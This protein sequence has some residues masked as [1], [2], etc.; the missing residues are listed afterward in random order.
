MTLGTEWRLGLFVD[1]LA[2]EKGLSDRTVDAYLRDV[3]R[4]VSWLEGSDVRPSR[5]DQVTP[6][7]LREHIYDLKDRSYAAST[8]RRA[9]AS[10]RAYFGFLVEEEGLATDPTRLLDTPRASRTLPEVLSVEAVTALLEDFPTDRFAYWRDRSILELLYATGMRVSELTGLEVTRVDLEEQLL[11]VLGKGSRERLLPFGG[12]ARRTLECYL[13]EERPRLDRGRGEGK[14]Y[15]GRTGRPLSRMAVWQ[16]VRDASKAAGLGE[17]VSPH[18]LRH[19]FA[20][21]LLE[22]GADL[23]AVQEL[24]GHADIS[25]TQIYT[26]LDRSHLRKVHRTAHPRA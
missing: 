17:G 11:L 5:P 19:S 2:L 3:E 23:A 13:R 22:A 24:L 18:T 10:L 9:Q 6:E 1:H 15:L 20:T 12:P 25:T 26:H 21:H 7:D 4:L 8:I 14:V 16:V